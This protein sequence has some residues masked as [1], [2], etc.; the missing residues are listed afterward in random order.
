MS[1]V[2]F[3]VADG[4]AH[5]EVNRAEAA[6]AFDL[7]TARAFAAAVAQADADDSVRVVLLTGAGKRFCAG[8]DVAS[9]VDAPEP[10]DYLLVLAT[11][12]DAAFRHL[13]DL[14]KPVVAVVQGAVAGAG[15][16]LMLAADVVI[17]SPE[18]KFVFAYPGIGATPDCGVSWLLPRT[19]GQ[20]RAL[21]FALLGKPIGA[22][23]ALDWGLVAEVDEAAAERGRTVAATFAAGPAL[24]LGQA[25][26]LIRSS[27]E[28]SREEAGAD[29]ARTIAAS[30]S[31]EESQTLIK[32]FLKR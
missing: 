21:S 31:T 24:A 8:G 14:A 27:A 2:N 30:V 20:Q 22:E 18:T 5:I 13:A 15:L 9:F 25:R 17:S 26:R 29:E 32:A 3:T 28:R 4:V 10:A 12:L 6:N 11:E 23:Q 7:P 19:I 16:G 1:V